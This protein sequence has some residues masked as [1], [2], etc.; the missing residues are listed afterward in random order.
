MRRW[1]LGYIEGGKRSYVAGK[2]TLK[3]KK[4]LGKNPPWCVLMIVLRGGAIWRVNGH[5]TPF[6][7]RNGRRD[8]ID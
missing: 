6:N 7:S 5:V 8:E 3:K 1:S 4:K 2:I